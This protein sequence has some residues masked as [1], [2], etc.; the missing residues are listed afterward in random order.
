MAGL[1]EILAW[2][3][4]QI[5]PAYF[6]DLA[7]RA[8]SAKSPSSTSGA[9]PAVSDALLKPGMEPAT[10][11]STVAQNSAYA[12]IW[13]TA[14]GNIGLLGPRLDLVWKVNNNMFKCLLL[15][16]AGSLLASKRRQNSQRPTKY[17][18]F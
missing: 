1:S 12:E 7:R 2:D 15:V 5:D 4:G 6:P 13:R 14:A 18:S 17:S 10:Y 11:C 8:I 16:I 3:A 9:W